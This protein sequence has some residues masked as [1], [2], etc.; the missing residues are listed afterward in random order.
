MSGGHFEP[1]EDTLGKSV[2]R[3]GRPGL[4]G[5][6]TTDT[7]DTFCDKPYT[8]APRTHAIKLCTQV[9][10]VSVVSSSGPGCGFERRTLLG[11][12][13]LRLTK[14]P[15]VDLWSMERPFP[16]EDAQRVNWHIAYL[17]AAPMDAVEVAELARL[18]RVQRWLAVAPERRAALRGVAI[19]SAVVRFMTVMGGVR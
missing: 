5:A 17:L 16:G 12:S 15:P 14:C 9:S 7:T 4:R 10:V 6:D 13:V 19:A 8:R 2:L 1:M 18:R 11:Q 3:D